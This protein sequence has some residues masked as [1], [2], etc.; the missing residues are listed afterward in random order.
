MIRIPRLPP[1]LGFSRW[2]RR[3]QELQ[4]LLRLGLFVILLVPSGVV[5]LNQRILIRETLRQWDSL[6]ERSRS[7]LHLFNMVSHLPIQAQR[8]I[9]LMP[10][11][12]T[13]NLFRPESRS[14][15][16]HKRRIGDQKTEI[17]VRDELGAPDLLVPSAVRQRMFPAKSVPKGHFFLFRQVEDEALD[18]V[19]PFLAQQCRGALLERGA[20]RA[21]ELDEVRDV[22]QF[23]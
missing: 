6:L 4:L 12:E 1:P 16:R 17:P 15:S 22:A 2:R 23:V 7:P 9:P 13:I 18:A 10:H 3:E 11:V 20:R 19:V 14:R 21:D 8:L 5:V